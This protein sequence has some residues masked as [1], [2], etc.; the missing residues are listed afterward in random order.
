MYTALLREPGGFHLPLS[1]KE[2]PRVV[3]ACPPMALPKARGHHHLPSPNPSLLK[4]SEGCHCLPS[5]GS[6]LWDGPG[7][8]HCLP[9]GLPHT[10]L[11]QRGQGVVIACTPLAIPFGNKQV[12]ITASPPLAL[13]FGKGYGV[14]TTCPLLALPLS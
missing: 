4:G 6:F 5:F 11:L 2:D 13:S 8:H 14:V 9:P 3:T 12:V 10:F 1:S 7:G